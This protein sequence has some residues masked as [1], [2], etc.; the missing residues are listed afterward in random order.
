M[1]PVNFPLRWESTGDQWW[2]ASPIDWAAAN[3]SYDI[4]RELLYLDANLLIKLTSLRRI[5][6]LETVWDDEAQFDDVARRRADVAL[7]LFRECAAEDAKSGAG[8][9]GGNSLIRAGYGGWLLYTAASAGDVA[10]VK[11]LL[12]GDPF[13]VFGEGE[14]GVT[15]LF[16]AAAR[17][18]NGE[19]FRLLVNSAIS[20]KGVSFSYV[21][22]DKL[23]EFPDSVLKS[24]MMN[25][26][27]HAATRGGFLE[28]VKE[29]LGQ[30]ADISSYRDHQGST[31]LHSAA[32]RGQLEVVKDLVASFGVDPMAKDH[33][34]N[35]AMHVAAYRGHLAVL[36]L[37]L[38]LAPSVTVTN[39][40]G[41][42]FL[43]MAVA[44]FRTPGFHRIDK[45]L[46]LLKH[47][48]SGGVVNNLR[49]LV[50]VRNNDGRTALH[51]ALAEN[52][53]SELVELLMAVPSIDL[54]SSD[55]DGM[56]PL[57]LLRK[58]ARSAGSD[59]LMKHLVSVGGRSSFIDDRTLKNAWVSKL[60]MQCIMNSPGT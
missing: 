46:E 21:G 50:N 53:P 23:G 36:D 8:G 6:R 60:K 30:G 14:Y 32:A 38:A 12:H 11:E 10:F 57:D 42:T 24:E 54:N 51:V 45:Q 25:R 41:D 22:G 35:T 48:V 13:L 59:F 44:G 47:V 49:E 52:V 19:V 29:I 2:Y 43:H 27:L 5:R 55:N 17:S 31:V 39:N 15:D 34:G 9:G 28:I 3:G 26:A 20:L 1:A 4:V 58:G 56:T 37:L 18:R 7:K 16:Y 33:Q 40:N